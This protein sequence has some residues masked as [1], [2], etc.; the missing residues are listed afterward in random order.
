MLDSLCEKLAIEGTVACRM[1][2]A[3]CRNYVNTIQIFRYSVPALML[4][5]CQIEKWQK[6]NHLHV[7]FGL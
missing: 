6:P 1:N 3:E 2:L 7:H 5:L 4:N